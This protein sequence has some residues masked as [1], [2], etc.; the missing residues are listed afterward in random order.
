M[1]FGDGPVEFL[2]IILSNVMEHLMLRDLTVGDRDVARASFKFSLAEFPKKLVDRLSPS[3]LK[4][5][6]G[7]C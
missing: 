2:P 5:G 1:H 4:K 6:G 3:K 7:V